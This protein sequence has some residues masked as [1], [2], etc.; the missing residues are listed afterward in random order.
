MKTLFMEVDQGLK[1]RS[2]LLLSQYI[3]IAH[4]VFA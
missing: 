3:I 1:I 4:I 2:A